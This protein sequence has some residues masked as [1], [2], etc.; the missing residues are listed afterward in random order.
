MDDRPKL[1]KNLDSS[2]FKNY[3]YLKEELMQ[4]CRQE[5]LQTV[6][7][8]IDLTERISQYLSTGEKIIIKSKSKPT[9][10]IGDIDEDTLI[11]NNFVCSEKH[12]AF[13]KQLV[14]KSFSF[15]VA[16]QN[17]LKSNV[18]KTYKDAVDAYHQILIDKKNGKTVIDKQFEYNTYIRDFF[19][20]NN[21]KS[22]DEAIKCWKYKKGTPGHNNYE[23][24]DLN[25]L[26][27]D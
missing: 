20:D 23:K 10:N 7:G 25:A 22:L 17:W 5:G 16:F 3:Y 26:I 13:F 24:T 1:N 21:D 6:G 8:K 12:R 18:G 2:T 4:F 19:A 15:N 14:G 11:E 27:I 9:V